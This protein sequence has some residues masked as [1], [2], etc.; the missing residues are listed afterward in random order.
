MSTAPKMQILITSDVWH[1]KPYPSRTSVILT[2]D[3]HAVLTALAIK[4]GLTVQQATY[5]F[6]K[7][8]IQAVMEQYP[9]LKVP[10]A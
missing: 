8:G 2:K 1:Y 10:R 5:F 6:L 7:Q 3:V 4:N 9:D